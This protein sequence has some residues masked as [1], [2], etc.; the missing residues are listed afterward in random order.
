MKELRETPR[1]FHFDYRFGHYLDEPRE[2]A[3]ED[4]SYQAGKLAYEASM[5]HCSEKKHRINH[6]R[7]KILKTWRTKYQKKLN[8]T[9]CKWV[10]FCY[11]WLQRRFYS[12][13]ALYS[14]RLEHIGRVERAAFFGPAMGIVVITFAISIS[15]SSREGF[16]GFRDVPDLTSLQSVK[17]ALISLSIALL[18][19]LPIDVVRILVHAFELKRRCQRLVRNII[20]FVITLL[21]IACIYK[22]YFDY[23]I[24]Y[25]LSHVGFRTQSAIALTIAAF[26]LLVLAPPHV[27]SFGMPIRFGFFAT[28]LV[29]VVAMIIFVP[30][31]DLFNQPN[32]SG[33]N[34]VVEKR[35]D[36]NN[37]LSPYHAELIADSARRRPNLIEKRVVMLEKLGYT[38]GWAAFLYVVWFVFGFMTLRH[39]TIPSY[40]D[41]VVGRR[42]GSDSLRSYSVLAHSKLHFLLSDF[43]SIRIQLFPIYLSAQINNLQKHRSDGQGKPLEIAPVDRRKFQRLATHAASKL[44]RYRRRQS[45]P[46]TRIAACQDQVAATL[47]VDPRRFAESICRFDATSFLDRIE[48]LRIRLLSTIAM[49]EEGY[50]EEL[51]RAQIFESVIFIEKLFQQVERSVIRHTVLLSQKEQRGDLVKILGNPASSIAVQIYAN[52][53]Q[54]LSIENQRYKYGLE[55]L[56]DAQ[57]VRPV[58][59]LHFL[60]SQILSQDTSEEGNEKLCR[61][62]RDFQNHTSSRLSQR[63][64]PFEFAGDHDVLRNVVGIVGQQIATAHTELLRRFDAIVNNLEDDRFVLVTL[65]YSFAVKQLINHSIQRE[66][67]PLVTA[68]FGLDASDARNQTRRLMRHEL[69]YETHLR[70][71]Q[72]L[73]FSIADITRLREIVGTN[74]KIVVLMGCEAYEQEPSAKRPKRAIVNV[75]PELM[76]ELHSCMDRDAMFEIWLVAEPYKRIESLATYFQESRQARVAG[77]VEFSKFFRQS[78]VVAP[79]ENGRVSK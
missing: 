69:L 33:I 68:C 53:V 6:E 36:E 18:I 16:L 34:S 11:I 50:S 64:H 4:D 17:T 72:V 32:P 40:A 74:Q 60:I 79:S 37:R 67:G 22:I 14:L 19:S 59:D 44:R 75:S 8:R 54:K 46:F 20:L 56:Y 77:V 47:R 30:Q 2:F 52:A 39:V 42:N 12:L 63:H 10:W 57:R 41:I 25:D 27:S 28:G 13:R 78:I 58:A 1:R 70:R 9:M 43:N 29:V 7:L 65:D 49:L 24:D 31:P 76:A 38:F 61:F 15:A 62:L 21:W 3:G 66:S 45:V 35:T 26:Y 48:Q 73:S 71:S 5:E 55:L 23:H 51:I